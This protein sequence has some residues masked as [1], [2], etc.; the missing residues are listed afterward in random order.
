MVCDSIGGIAS[1]RDMV[2]VRFGQRRDLRP[3]EGGRRGSTG[4]SSCRQVREFREC[5][6]DRTLTAYVVLDLSTQN[7]TVLA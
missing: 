1:R 6:L 4:C 3:V 2:V 5:L 7:S